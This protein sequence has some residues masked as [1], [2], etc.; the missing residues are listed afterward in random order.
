[1]TNYSDQIKEDGSMPDYA[2][3]KRKQTTKD[4]SNALCKRIKD[5][6]EQRGGVANIVITSGT[7]RKGKEKKLNSGGYFN[8]TLQQSKSFYSKSLATSGAS[9]L[10][11]L[12][13]SDKGELIA[14]EC[15][16]KIGADKQSADQ[17]A[18]QQSIERIKPLQGIC[19]YS[20]VK[21]FDDF[22]C[23]YSQLCQR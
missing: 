15:E 4:N 16:V 23:Q 7:F 19:V 9:D 10:S 1:M 2:K 17:Y 11:I 20:I 18:Y 21:T 12:F 3:P 6:V 8:V 14:F 13:K 5:Y 22:L